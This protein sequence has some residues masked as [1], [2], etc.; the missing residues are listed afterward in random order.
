MK[1]FEAEIE[2]LLG[3]QQRLQRRLLSKTWPMETER[4]SDTENTPPASDPGGC[5]FFRID[6]TD[7]GLSSPGATQEG[8]ELWAVNVVTYP[9]AGQCAAAG[10][11]RHWHE[12]GGGRNRSA[13]PT[14]RAGR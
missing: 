10:L 2:R 9:D 1:D 3:R 6:T 5:Q 4:D 12:A 14:G 7:S 13:A 8:S 11:A